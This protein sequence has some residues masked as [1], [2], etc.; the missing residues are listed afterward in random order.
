MDGPDVSNWQPADILAHVPHDFA[1]VKATQGSQYIS[2]SFDQQIKDALNTGKA[3]V[4]HFD[5]G[6]A[7][8]QAECDHFLA[9][10]K[11]YIGRMIV[12]WDW[13]ASAIPAGAGRLSQILGYLRSKLGFPPV[14]YASG[15]PLVSTGGNQAAADNNCGVWC[16]NYSLGYQRIDGYRRDLKPYTACIMHQYTSSGH[17]PGYDGNLDLNQFFG[18]G[19]MWDAYATGKPVEGGSTPAPAPAKK[20]NEEIANEVLAGQWGNGTDRKARLTAAGYDYGTIQNIVNTKVGNPTAAPRAS[21]DVIAD[22]VIAGA[23]GNNPERQQRLQ[24]AGY[25][26]NAIQAIVNQKTGGAP[27]QSQRLSIDTVANQVIAGAWGNDPQRTQKLQAAG[28]DAKAVQDAVNA[29]LGVSV[30]GKASNDAVANQVIHGD[31]GNNPERAQ[32]LRA[33][34]YDPNAIQALVNRKLGV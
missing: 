1:N 4:Y 22:Q 17:L 3:G 10:I 28:Y 11:P 18:D 19:K 15:S 32:R 29:K 6:D 21:N 24:A 25:D 33:A 34:G 14:L 9:T 5:N 7:N 26:Y 13:E 8:W 16:A 23:W 31:W 30:A 27:A 20:S 2:P 12:I